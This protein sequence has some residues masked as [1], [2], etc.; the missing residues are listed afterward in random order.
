MDDILREL[1]A[2]FLGEGRAI[3]EELESALL[4]LDGGA[5]GPELMNRLFRLAHNFKGSS[6]AVGFTAVADLAHKLED[7]LTALKSGALPLHAAVVTAMLDAQDALRRGLD[8]AAAGDTEA[9]TLTAA[10]AA[11]AAVALAPAAAP[12]RDAGFGFFDDEPATT[13]TATTATATTATATTATATTAAA[14]PPAAPKAASAP[15]RAPAAQAD[16]LLRIPAA[17]LDALLNLVGELVV[18]RT[19]LD[20][21]RTRGSVASPTA[22]QT[23]AYVSKLITDVQQIALGLRLVEV[24]PLLQKLRRTARDVAA[25]LG[26]DVELVAEGEHVEL[27]KSVLDS[28]SDPLTHMVR[29]AVDH[30]CDTPE[31]RE[32]AGK[33]RTAKVRV[34]AVEQEDR[35]AITI[36][37]DGRGLDRE[38]ILRK[39]VERG[40]VS[41]GA[42]LSDHQIHALIFHPGFSTKD[43]VSDISG[44]GVGMEVV[45]RA[46]DELKGTI[47]IES[48]PGRGTRFV[49]TLPLS[50]SI[51]GGMVVE[52]GCRRFVLPVSQMA[53]TIDL[54]KLRVETSAAAGPMINLRGEVVPVYSLAALLKLP[55][56]RDAA[57][58]RKRPAI[59]AVH[60]GRKVSFEVD[61]ILSQQH[62]VLKRL[63]QPFRGLPGIMAGAILSDGEPGLVLNLHE[64]IPTGGRDVA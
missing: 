15:P 3:L 48:S 62:V 64:L 34:A 10:A 20:E 28:I 57:S 12:S 30:G 11:L 5:S 47:E 4:E 19:I 37:D 32:K 13:A 22:L 58:G 39:A 33:P 59:L 23:L 35:V 63:G 29:N 31:E 7:V 36:E 41:P 40:L 14:K 60:R 53:E 1:Q 44:R 25:Q 9:E 38:R 18:N 6:R 51:I 55:P 24:R 50:L 49:I 42:P 2:T 43:A 27:D 46:V 26:R 56:P 21:H 8:A 52:A 17:R 54:S 61:A 45:Q 16:E